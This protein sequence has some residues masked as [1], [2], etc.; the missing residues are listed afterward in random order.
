MQTHQRTRANVASIRMSVCFSFEL[1]LEAMVLKE[2]FVPLS[3][4]M[5]YEID[6][7]RVA[8]KGNPTPLPLPATASH[9]CHLIHIAPSVLLNCSQTIRS[10]NCQAAITVVCLV[11]T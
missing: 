3:S 5:S 9:S 8:T 4:A 6:I 2:E 11:V 7:M 1:R 10:D